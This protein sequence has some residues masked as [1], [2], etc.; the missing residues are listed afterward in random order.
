V[1]SRLRRLL[2]AAV[3]LGCAASAVAAGLLEELAATPE[4]WPAEVTVLTAARGTVIRDGRPAGAMLVG[5]GRTLAVTKIGAEGVTGRL[6]GTLVV[7]PADRTDLHARVQAPPPAGATV[8]A[9]PVPPSPPPS[10]GPA[11]RVP[12][13][14]QRM[15]G[16]KL[17]RLDGGRLRPMEAAAIA[18][19]RVFAL[20]YSASWCGPCRQFTPELVRAHRAL[21]EKHPHFEVVFISADR[22]AGD[23][24]DYMRKD[25]MAF[26]AVDFDKRDNKLMSFSGPGIPCLVLVDQNGKVLSDSYDGDNYRGPQ[27]V[28]EDARRIL[29]GRG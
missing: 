26:P 11:R 13:M 12:A 28:L 14:M 21:K 24:R 18:D 7:V 25:G 10:A 23:M 9:A 15:L 1:V 6:G 8:A 16:D 3:L 4:R 22:S 2:T 19:V 29:A 27:A 20:Y 17:V 5:A